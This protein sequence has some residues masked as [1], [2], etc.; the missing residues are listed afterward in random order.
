MGV[1]NM[2]KNVILMSVNKVFIFLA[3]VFFVF[4][5]YSVVLADCDSDYQQCAESVADVCSVYSGVQKD[6][7]IQDENVSCLDAQTACKSG[8]AGQSGGTG[9]NGVS[10]ENVAAAMQQCVS[11]HS[12]CLNDAEA[13]CE[14]MNPSDPV[15]KDE[16]VSQKQIACESQK[17]A[18]EQSAQSGS[19][20][21]GPSCDV[22]YQECTVK[23]TNACKNL[24]G[25]EKTNCESNGQFSCQSEKS[26][27]EA[28]QGASSEASFEPPKMPILINPLGGTVEVPEGLNNIPRL[29]GKIISVGL[30]FLGSVALLFFVYGGLLWMTSMGDSSRVQQGTRTLMWAALG[31][32][33]VFSAYA[34]TLF[35]IGFIGA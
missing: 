3:S 18:C 14:A 34:L 2:Q 33:F 19:A 20:S 11:Q 5:S 26:V 13:Q 35:I 9:Q 29:V 8:G 10:A 12:A 30:G 24:Q 32:V 4:G 7:C 31:I 16:C 23:V 6:E 1:S 21:A 17:I 28:Q 27:C 25:P 22:V 15:A